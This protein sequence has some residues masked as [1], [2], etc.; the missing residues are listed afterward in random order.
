[1]ETT[2]VD[3]GYISYIGIMEKKTETTVLGFCTRTSSRRRRAVA[4]SAS[5]QEVLKLVASCP[6]KV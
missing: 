2:I 1:M 4:S 5:S 6:Y 3:W